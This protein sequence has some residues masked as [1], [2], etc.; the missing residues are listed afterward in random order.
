MWSQAV[1][2]EMRF[3]HDIAKRG[4]GKRCAL[5]PPLPGLD[6]LCLG[7]I[8]GSAQRCP[9]CCAR[10]RPSCGCESARARTARPRRA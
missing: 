5:G 8:R 6:R 7:G 10:L 9:S 4:F 3:A 1:G 2:R